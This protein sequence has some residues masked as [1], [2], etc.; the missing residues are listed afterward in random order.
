M[1]SPRTA[2]ACASGFASSTVTILPLVTTRSA[3]SGVAW[4]A[5][6]EDLR[7]GL[8]QVEVALATPEFFERCARGVG[9]H[10]FAQHRAALDG[11]H[12]SAMRIVERTGRGL[13]EA[14]L[15]GHSPIVVARLGREGLLE[16]LA[17]HYAA[18]DV[19]LVCLQLLEHQLVS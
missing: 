19:A 4:H 18:G 9:E 16:P 17:H 8:D 3:G 2:T 15:C 5:L 6:V 13:A 14:R 1:R 12:L 11:A 7:E 10:R